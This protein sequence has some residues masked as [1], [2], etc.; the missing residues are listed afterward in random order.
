MINKKIGE[1]EEKLKE[2]L[3]EEFTQAPKK[4]WQK[5][6]GYIVA[7]IGLVVALAWNDA[8]QALVKVLF[9]LDTGS[10]GAKF[11]YAVVITVVLVLVAG[12]LGKHAEK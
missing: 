9:P 10:V 5:S 6:A 1:L 3:K 7:G 11:V 2:E 4:V 8:V 12:K